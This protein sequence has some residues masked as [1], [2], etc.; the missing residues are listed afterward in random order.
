MGDEASWD[1]DGRRRGKAAVAG[2]EPGKGRMPFAATWLPA[3]CWMSP[4]C[5]R[6][7]GSVCPPLASYRGELSWRGGKPSPW[8]LECMLAVGDLIS[9]A[10]ESGVAPGSRGEHMVL[11]MVLG[12]KGEGI[13]C[14]GFRSSPGGI[15]RLVWIAIEADGAG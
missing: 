14:V 12:V 2:G 15:G 9:V 3:S 13:A 6:K 5:D 1:K 4:N 10:M 7:G 8:L 11:G